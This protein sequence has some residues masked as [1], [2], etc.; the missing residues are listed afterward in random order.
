MIPS[1]WSRAILHVDM[2]AFYASVEQRDHPEW[3]GI[4]VLV[5][6]H[7]NERGVVSAASYEARA[8]GTRSAMPMAQA[9]RLC[10][11]ARRV[12]PRMDVYE[13]ISA[14][15]HGVFHE[16]TPLVQPVS[17]DEAY[18]DV[19]GCQT[20]FGPPMLIAKK[21]KQAI[22]RAVNLNA[23]VGVAPNR[24]VAKIA[25]DLEKPDGLTVI[26]EDAILDRLAPLPVGRIWGVGPVT[27][28]RLKKLGILTVQHLRAWTY[29]ALEVHFGKFGRDLYDMAR[30]IDHSLVTVDEAEKSISQEMTFSVDVVDRETLEHELLRQSENVAR[31]LRAQGLV[32]RTVQLK[33]RY[34]D[35]STVTRRVTLP[36]PL[37]VTEII[38]HAAVELMR[39]RTEAGSRPVRLIG[40][41][42]QNLSPGDAR[43]GTLFDADGGGAPLRR[44]RV[45][46]MV[47]RIREKLGDDSIRR[48][49]LWAEDWEETMAEDED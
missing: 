46:R 24:F 28:A 2:D 8:F 25:S 4:P 1:Y 40:V 18:L 15:I 14:T 9:L 17:L 39:T 10:P 38:Y 16:F 32:A 6:G 48:A 47:D 7:P 22:R 13:D 43:Q 26:P 49:S 45:E 21:I 3:R 23:S 27:E 12:T 36:A 44:E 20:L 29:S 41:G 19:T 33:L 30:G 31:R 35:F 37:C 5:G 11:H 34:D 42:A